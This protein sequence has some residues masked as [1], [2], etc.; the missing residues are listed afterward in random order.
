MKVTKQIIFFI[1]L[2]FS[3]S[4]SAQSPDQFLQSTLQK[5]NSGDPNA[6]NLLGNLY[7]NGSGGVTKNL[8]EAKTWFEAAA[9]KGLPAGYFNL[10][11]MYERGEV[12]PKDMTK[13]TQYFKIAAN[14]GLPAAQKKL[15]SLSVSSTTS[16]PAQSCYKVEDETHAR[17]SLEDEQHNSCK[18]R[19][20]DGRCLRVPVSA[21]CPVDSVVQ[22]SEAQS[23]E[24]FNRYSAMKKTANQNSLNLYNYVKSFDGCNDYKQI[25][26]SCAGSGNYDQC[27]SIRFGKSY[28]SMEKKCE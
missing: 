2:I 12:V 21:E 20:F 11:L 24:V 4:S 25:R 7:A 3:L 8:N 9:N 17:T 1:A 15:E 28:Q 14:G 18:V 5:A 6:M 16:K 22:I 26:Y 13:A 10:G 19:L 27:M 23:A